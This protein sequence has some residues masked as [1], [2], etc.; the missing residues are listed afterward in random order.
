V[1]KDQTRITD[2]RAGAQ[3]GRLSGLPAFVEPESDTNR[4]QDAEPDQPD[5][6]RRPI[7]L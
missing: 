6:P 5:Q 3:A 7:G 2:D 4:W 1:I